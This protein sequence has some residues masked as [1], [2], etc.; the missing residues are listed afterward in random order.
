MKPEYI[1]VKMQ[2]VKKCKKA[3]GFLFKG[4]FYCPGIINF[5]AQKLV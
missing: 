2:N 1:C 4:L 3:L 5:F